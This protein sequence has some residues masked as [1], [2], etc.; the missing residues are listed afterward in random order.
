V[1]KR[2]AKQ[3]RLIQMY[4]GCKN[5][6]CNKKMFKKRLDFFDPIKFVNWI[7]YTS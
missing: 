7:L 4:V 1:N 6:E 3:L 2:V 5:D